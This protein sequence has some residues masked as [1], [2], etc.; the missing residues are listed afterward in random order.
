MAQDVR[1]AVAARDAASTRVRRLTAVVTA[2]CVGSTALFAGLAA[3]STHLRKVVRRE[4]VPVAAA[5]R[6]APVHAP[7]PPLVAVQS[8]A[9]APAPPPVPA[10]AAVPQAPVVVSGGS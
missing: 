8:S 2:V 5:R 6:Q 9:P 3:G 4:H 1:R 10:P 7:A